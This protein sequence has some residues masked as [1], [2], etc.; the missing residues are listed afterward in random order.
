MHLNSLHVTNGDS[1]VELFKAGGIHGEFLPWRDVMHVG[2]LID[3]ES[4]ED[5]S[6]IRALY[7]AYLKWDTLENLRA[8]FEQRDLKLRKAERYDQI[9]LW[10]EHDLYDQLQL[11]QILDYVS[12]YPNLL[13]KTQLIQTSNYIGY[14]K[15]EQILNLFKMATKVTHSQVQTASEIFDAFKKG[16]VEMLQQYSESTVDGLPCLARALKRLTLELPSEVTGCTR[17]EEY[18]LELINKGCNTR[19]KL[20]KEYCRQEPI[21]FHGDQSFF[22]VVDQM[23]V[24]QPALISQMPETYKLTEIGSKVLQNQQKWVRKY[25]RFHWLG[26]HSISGHSVEELQIAV[27]G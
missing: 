19:S 21:Q 6:N 4:I 26:G 22:W 10:F 23:C 15:P 2:P 3:S 16:N 17:T 13:E 8:D 11:I 7:L 20:F 5:I 1:A 12:N 9:Y 24:D 25:S 27:N 18:I 14:H